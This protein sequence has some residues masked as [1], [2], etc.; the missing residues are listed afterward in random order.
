MKRES[1][2][3]IIKNKFPF[4]VS[5]GFKEQLDLY[6]QPLLCVFHKYENKTIRVF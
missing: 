6:K 1:L 3:I 4:I 5:I 2:V